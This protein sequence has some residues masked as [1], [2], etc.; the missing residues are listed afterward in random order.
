MERIKYTIRL[1][2][3]RQMCAPCLAENITLHVCKRQHAVTQGR[4]QWGR[5]RRTPPL[6]L[7]EI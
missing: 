3:D 7:E 5:T 6:K 1:N 2:D 4:I